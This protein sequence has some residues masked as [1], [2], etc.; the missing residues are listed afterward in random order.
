MS[1]QANSDAIDLKVIFNKVL[2]NWYWFAICAGILGAIGVAYIKTTPKTYLVTATMLLNEQ[3]RAAFGSQNDEFLKGQSYLKG[4]SAIEDMTA[5]L[6]SYKNV[7]NTLRALDFTVSYH[8][9]KNYLS[10]EKYDFRPFYVTFDSTAAT[11]VVE[12]PIVVSIDTIAGTYELSAKGKNVQLFNVKK[13]ELIP[14]EFVPE[15]EINSGT[16]KMGEPFT[17]EHLSVNIEF[18]EDRKYDGDTEY[19][20]IIHSLENQA[21]YF[22]SKLGVEPLSDESNIITLVSTGEIVTKEKKFLD[23]LMETYIENEKQKRQEK[24][25]KTIGFIDELIGVASDSLK[26]DEEQLEQ[27][28]TAEATA[29]D[30]GILQADASRLEDDLRRERSKLNYLNSLVS[31]LR[32][33]NEG[34]NV[35]PPS[36]FG[37]D[38]PVLNNTVDELIRLNADIKSRPS[39]TLNDPKLM[40]MRR[41]RSSLRQSLAGTADGLVQQTEGQIEQLRSGLGRINYKLTSIPRSDGRKAVKVRAAE[42]SENLYTYLQEKR[43]EAGIAIASDQIDKVVVDNAARVGNSAIAPNKKIILG[44]ALLLGLLIPLGVILVRDL[45]D[46][47][48]ADMDELK[49]VSPVPVLASIPS[50][51][52][53]RITPDE[54]KS[55]LAES[56]RTARIN[57]QYLNPNKDTSIIGVTS[58]TSGEGKSFC[59][60]NMATIMAMSGKRTI[61]IDCDMRRPRVLEYLSMDSKKGLSSYLIDEADVDD[62]IRATD[63]SGLDVIGAGPIPPNPLELV[64]TPR[65]NTLFEELRKRYDRIV[66]D[67]S[68]MGLVSEYVIL[69]QHIDVTLYV[70]R[71]NRTEKKTLDFLN[72]NYSSGKFKNVD[73]VLNDVKSSSGPSGDQYGYYTK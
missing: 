61:L 45:L 8:E 9:K 60:I 12:I 32:S 57:L 2:S 55:Q 43:A 28:L 66:L 42:L 63:I 4:S 64:E 67:A 29:G 14:D 73:L 58:S 40:A 72:E 70:V 22:R 41:R 71:A 44:G 19:S 34:S 50:S 26:R 5:V 17:S 33:G 10:K 6:T 68:P 48:I 49:R 35:S 54:P 37:L 47:T 18:P 53:K 7:A 11:Q 62:I 13:Q 69:M 24:G 31:Q 20:F 3:G 46:D 38:V 23:K 39:S 27:V 25:H 21:T 16:K 30:M 59:A 65:F 15:Y 52:R 51:K 36:A 56:F 1:T